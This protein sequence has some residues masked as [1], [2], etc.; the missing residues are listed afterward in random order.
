MA[1]HDIQKSCHLLK[2]LEEKMFFLS[3][4]VAQI[5]SLSSQAQYVSSG[6]KRTWLDVE[7]KHKNWKRST[8]NS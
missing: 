3:T 8:E 4:L 7:Q 1:D 5:E 6:I 2:H